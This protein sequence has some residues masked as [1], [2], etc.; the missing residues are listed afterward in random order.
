MADQSTD[1]AAKLQE[2]GARL[3]AG[4]AKQHPAQ[5]LQTVCGAVRQQW[6]M[7]QRTKRAK[8]ASPPTPPKSKGKG[9]G[10]EPGV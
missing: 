3:R 10:I 5:H 7:E 8:S 6:E 9:P 2:L 4:F 1:A